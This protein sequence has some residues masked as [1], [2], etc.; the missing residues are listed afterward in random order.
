[1]QAMSVLIKKKLYSLLKKFH[2]LTNNVTF[3][4]SKA[5]EGKT[6]PFLIPYIPFKSFDIYLEDKMN[7]ESIP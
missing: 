1:M 5:G 7:P 6:M 3:D 2:P 4:T